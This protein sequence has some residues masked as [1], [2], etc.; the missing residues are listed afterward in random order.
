LLDRA[1]TGIRVMDIES[2][3]VGESLDRVIALVRS[4]LQTILITDALRARYGNGGTHEPFPLGGRGGAG[5]AMM[6]RYT[7]DIPRMD[8]K[9]PRLTRRKKG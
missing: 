8:F 9:I 1:F 4:I 2:V 6:E 3:P 5:G 7:F